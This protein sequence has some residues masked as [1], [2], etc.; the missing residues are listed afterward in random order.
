MR[1]ERGVKIKCHCGGVIVDQ[2]DY[3]PHKAHLIPD[4]EWFDLLEVIDDAI[5]RSGPDAK[6]K[7]AACMAVHSVIHRM[8]RLAWQCRECGRLYID[9]L[10]HELR[11]FLPGSADVPREL[12]RSHPSTEA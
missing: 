3:L 9:D 4:Q 1:R 12:F 2:T 5:E 8:A 7:E 11:E 10:G 6:A